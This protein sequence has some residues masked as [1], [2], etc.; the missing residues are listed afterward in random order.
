M[1]L[2]LY[3]IKCKRNEVD[4][5][6]YVG[7]PLHKFSHVHTKY[8]SSI[9]H[10]E[11]ILQFDTTDEKA[12][13]QL[14]RTNYCFVHMLQRYY[15]IDDIQFMNGNMVKLICSEDVL[16]TYCDQIKNTS[17]MIRRNEKRYNGFY[18]DEKYPITNKKK[19]VIKTIGGSPFSKSDMDSGKRC[20]MLT[21][22]GGAV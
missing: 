15:F 6:K 14:C 20:I 13:E 2:Y 7:K 21:T 4:K 22:N 10:L 1:T 11:I 19:I 9:M 16:F 17:M 3:Q 12:T 8:T 5:S 18:N